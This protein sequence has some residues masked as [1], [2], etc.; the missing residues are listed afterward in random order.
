MARF[1]RLPRCAL[2]ARRGQLLPLR[3][4]ELQSHPA[5]AF[6]R[7]IAPFMNSSPSTPPSA[8]RRH[9]LWLPLAVIVLGAAAYLGIH[10]QSELERNFQA[11]MT[12][13]LGM[14]IVLLLAG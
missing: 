5:R 12:A 10:A 9:R 14:L 3:A 1:A 11:W 4:A 6:P 2:F 7:R 13:S 8:F